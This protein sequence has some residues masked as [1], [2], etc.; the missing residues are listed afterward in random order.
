M[1]RLR[2]KRGE[3]CTVE[4]VGKVS[5][6]ELPTLPGRQSTGVT[7]CLFLVTRSLPA[8][9]MKLL[10]SFL[11]LK[12]KKFHLLRQI[13]A[14]SIN[15]Q[16]S[17]INLASKQSASSLPS[18]VSAS[19]D[20]DN[21]ET[22]NQQGFM[23][24]Y[25]SEFA[26]SN[27]LQ[28]PNDAAQASVNASSVPMHPNVHES[29]KANRSAGNANDKVDL[30]SVNEKL[31]RNLRKVKG[32]SQ[33]QLICMECGT[34]ESPEWRKGPTGPKMLCNACG[35]R[36]AKQQKRLKRATKIS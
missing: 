2:N 32:R 5:D 21:Y 27:V 18:D 30:L 28:R 36:W 20:Y 22:F 29:F 16:T 19:T 25:A 11:D 17:P 9:K 7:K 10:D 1:Y 23:G 3:S 26:P 15:G 33:K 12:L 8:E 35:L 4:S 24:D 34:S 6:I 13:S 31:H 14:L